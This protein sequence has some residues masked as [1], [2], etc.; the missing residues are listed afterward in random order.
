M[1]NPGSTPELVRVDAGLYHVCDVCEVASTA[2]PAEPWRWST[3]PATSK[4]P[5]ALRDGS[6]EQGPSSCSAARSAL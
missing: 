4:I 1:T 6:A 2:A 3:N 5:L